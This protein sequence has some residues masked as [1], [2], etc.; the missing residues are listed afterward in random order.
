MIVVACFTAAMVVFVLG[1]I[2]SGIWFARATGWSLNSVPPQP[3]AADEWSDAD[4]PDVTD[5]EVGVRARGAAARTELTQTRVACA[6]IRKVM[7]D[8]VAASQPDEDR[9]RDR[10][11]AG[12]QI[13]DA[14]RKALERA[15]ADG[16]IEATKDL[17]DDIVRRD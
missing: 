8:R 4:Y 10:L 7:L 15:V 14:I 3:R 5:A 16:E 6:A 2:G 11:I 9:L 17:M 13:I 1:V 12:V